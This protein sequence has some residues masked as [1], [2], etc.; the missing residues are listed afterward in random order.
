MANNEILP[1][2]PFLYISE[3]LSQQLKPPEMAFLLHDIVKY[4]RDKRPNE[5]LPLKQYMNRF[6]IILAHQ[7]PG[8]FYWKIFSRM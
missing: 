7:E 4:L 6:R 8:D 2:I 3:I 5:I 1:T